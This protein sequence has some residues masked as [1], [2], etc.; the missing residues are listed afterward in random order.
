MSKQAIAIYDG[1]VGWRGQAQQLIAGTAWNA[2][3]EFVQANPQHFRFPDGGEPKAAK[4]DADTGKD[5]GKAGQVD[6]A[7]EAD[8]PPYTEWKLADLQQEAADRGLPTSGTKADLAA[9][10]EQWDAD[11]P[12]A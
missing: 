4:E 2:D 1:F 5:A 9:R 7:G 8:L 6:T 12:D 11:N 3:H 10:L